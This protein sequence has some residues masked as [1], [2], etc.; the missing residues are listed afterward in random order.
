MMNAA[1]IPQFP[2]TLPSCSLPNN[3]NNVESDE[4][5]DDEEIDDLAGIDCLDDSE[6][7]DENAKESSMAPA[8][9]QS[10]STKSRP[11]FTA[12]G[13][14][15]TLNLDSFYSL[16]RAE[17]ATINC[18]AV[19][20]LTEKY[21]KPVYGKCTTSDPKT[22]SLRPSDSILTNAEKLMTPKSNSTA[23]APTAVEIGQ[24]G[25]FCINDLAV[26]KK[27]SLISRTRRDL[28]SERNWLDS[29]G[30][31]DKEKETIGIELWHQSPS[32]VVLKHGPKAIDVESL[33]Y[34]ALE[35]YIDN[36]TID[37]TIACFLEDVYESGI[38]DTIYLPSELWQ[39]TGSDDNT[40]LHEKLKPLLLK[41]QGEKLKQILVPVHMTNHWGLVYVDLQNHSLHFD[42]GMRLVPGGYVLNGV[43]VVLDAYNVM[44]P[45]HEE[46]STK[47]WSINGVSFSRFG[48]P[49]QTA[50][51][52]RQP[53]EGAGSCGIGVKKCAR[54]LITHGPG[55]KYNFT[56]S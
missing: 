10:S 1:K 25:V 4:D 42:D 31:D 18:P 38:K 45:D 41:L 11:L 51:N 24:C 23:P 49:S 54:D 52:T 22:I 55:A 29:S 56:W 44:L 37:I 2:V 20:R 21:L 15:T 17:L 48:M 12:G 27:Y 40:F 19:V 46:L 26:L 43:M 5:A 50:R 13:N 35:R 3:N 36:M 28:A 6:S 39:W 53:G 7:L 14:G 34:L 47:F 33:S 16:T 9:K 8:E 32:S 30:L